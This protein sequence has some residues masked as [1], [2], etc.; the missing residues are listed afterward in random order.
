MKMNE[1]AN[2]TVNEAVNINKKGLIESTP[3][4]DVI[5][6]SIVA[7]LLACIVTSLILGI[8][9]LYSPQAEHTN[10]T[11]ILALLCAISCMALVVLVIRYRNNTTSH[12]EELLEQREQYFLQE[13]MASLGQMIAGVAHEINTP[14]AY[15]SNN[16]ELMHR[17][18]KG[19]KNDVI[20]PVD[21]LQKLPKKSIADIL[22]NQRTMITN[23]RSNNYSK[24]LE[25]TINLSHDAETGLASISELVATLKDFSRV[26]RQEEDHA[27][28]HELLDLTLKI[29]E[30]HID[31][32][33]VELIR[34]YDANLPLWLCQPSK[35][36]QVFLNLIV[37]ACHAIIG[38]GKLLISTQYDQ[39]NQCVHIKFIDN[40]MGMTRK[41]RRSLFDPFYTTKD[42]GSGT[43]LGMSIVAS[44]IKEHAG[45]IDVNSHLGS[46]TTVSIIL[47]AIKPQTNSAS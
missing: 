21:D 1:K 40:G 42:I 14:L 13:K 47:P 27:D 6:F 4:S 23:V 44:I 22:A 19:V 41:T 33:H 45:Q 31:S 15:V 46:G 30:R 9:A 7:V 39:A 37:N 29:T 26:D 3:R 24:K 2:E 36:N 38:G 32:N 34:K 43:G 17:C 25:R 8:Q 12:D 20:D 28:L 35:L 16:V 11:I 5:T 18:L 10:S